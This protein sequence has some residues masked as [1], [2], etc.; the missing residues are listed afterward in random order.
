MLKKL[1][2]Y[3]WKSIWRMI[4]L[5]NTFTVFITILGIIAMNLLI[6]DTAPQSDDVL[7]LII[8][9]IFTLYYLTIIGVFFAINIYIGIRFYKNLYTDEGYLMH[10]LPLK[11]SQLILSKLITHTLA[12]GITQLLLLCSIGALLLPL[13][14]AVEKDP[15]YSLLSL[16]ETFMRLCEHDMGIILGLPAFACLVSLLGIICSTLTIYCAISLGQCFF[17]HKVMGSVLCYIALYFV[18]Q[19]VNTI[20]MLPTMS[21]T[22]SDTGAT[23]DF[24]LLEYF[25]H[26]FTFSCI[27]CVLYSIIF[28]LITYFTMEKNLNLD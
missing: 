1:I 12:A 18:L 3:E 6:V 24:N 17:K 13:L 7:S 28:Y 16:W 9:L 26:I 15:N 27:S 11:K 21:F 8:I 4:L 14:A 19:I 22:I 20:F 2:K 25:F 5:I 23:L 10:T